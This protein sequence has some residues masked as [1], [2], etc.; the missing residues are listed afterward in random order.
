MSGGGSR[1][2]ERE[3]LGVELKWNCWDMNGAEM[4]KHR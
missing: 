2:S 4:E 3:W 1:G